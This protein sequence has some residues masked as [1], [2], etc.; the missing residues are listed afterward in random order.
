MKSTS[1]SLAFVD[2]LAS[3]DYEHL[4]RTLAP[5]AVARFLLPRG[6]QET[7]GRDAIARRFEGWFGGAGNFTVLSTENQQVGNRR[8]LQWRFRLSR[9]GSSTEVIEQV[10]FADEG[11]AGIYRLD[12]LCS[13]FLTEPA[14][15]SCDV[16]AASEAS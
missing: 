2:H 16:P 7:L 5:D 6:P 9:D 1:Q 11:P 12:L 4:A 14:P 13:G 8:L 3:R 10:A 15:A